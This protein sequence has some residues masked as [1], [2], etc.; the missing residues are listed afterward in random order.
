MSVLGRRNDSHAHLQYVR[1]RRTAVER[2]NIER[3][4]D[5]MGPM[6]M[7]APASLGEDRDRTGS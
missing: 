7:L 3:N 2:K 4:V 6:F 5:L 1:H